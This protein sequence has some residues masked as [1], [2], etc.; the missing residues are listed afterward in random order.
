MCLMSCGELTEKA[1][2]KAIKPFRDKIVFQE[3][4]S[5]Y[6]QKK[7][8][9]QMLD[10]C[11]TKWLIPLDADIVLNDIAFR[12]IEIAIAEDGVD[13]KVH[14]ILFPLWD[15]LTEKRILALKILRMEIMKQFSFSES[16]TPDVEH[17]K[18]LTEAGYLCVDRH[19]TE[20]VIGEHVVKGPKF[21][22]HKY[23]DVYQTLRSHGFEW[24]SGAF[25]GGETTIEKSR[26]HFEFFF[27][28]LMMTENND[29][30]YCIAGMVDGL[31]SPM[32][33]KSKSLKRKN[34]RIKAKSAIDEYILWY[35]GQQVHSFF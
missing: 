30:L 34:F 3:V 6:P 11:K 13:P 25:M 26:K 27:H 10:Q 32:E 16:A 22:Y 12:R 29:Y 19:L 28:K 21:C 31:T 2:L 35:N 8:L 14:S 17:F 23:K 15:T 24:D 1:C 18:R 5:V 7:A 20:D 9:N 4:R 33:H